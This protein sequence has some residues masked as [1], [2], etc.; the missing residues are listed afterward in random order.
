MTLKILA[1]SAALILGGGAVFAAAAPSPYDPPLKTV[2]VALPKD[3]DNPQSKPKV[4]CAYFRGFMVKEVDLG[5]EGA[6]QL[7]IV[8]G[9]GA[10]ACRR[11]NVAA[12]RVVSPKDWSGYFE[13][14]KGGFVVFSGDDGWNGGMGFAVVDAGSGRKLFDDAYKARMAALS[15]G[16]SSLKLRYR[17]VYAA[18]C[19]LQADPAG[20]WRQVRQATGLSG[21]APDCAAAYAKEARRTPK[22]AKEVRSDPTV[23]DYDAEAVVDARGATI[24]P[25]TSQA[26]ACRPA[27]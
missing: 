14:A 15:A 27:D 6:D 7:S 21:A 20:C 5:E 10:Q 13:G 11:E 16:P 26:A 24:H 22:F 4:I 17:R 12:E 2:R 23:F 9:A 19:S 8:P 3:P 18:K 1:A 25:T